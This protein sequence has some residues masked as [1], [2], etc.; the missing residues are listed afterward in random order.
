MENMKDTLDIDFE[1]WDERIKGGSPTSPISKGKMLTFG[2]TEE[3][4]PRLHAVPSP[5]RL[6]IFLNTGYSIIFTGEGLQEIMNKVA[7]QEVMNRL[8]EGTEEK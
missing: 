5:A 7:A 2:Y 8:K 6:C 3:H 4:P 1:L